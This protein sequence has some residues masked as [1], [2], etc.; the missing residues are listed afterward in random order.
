VHVVTSGGSQ[1]PLPQLAVPQSNLQLAEVSPL[2][3]VLLPQ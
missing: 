3:Q 2:S 1:N